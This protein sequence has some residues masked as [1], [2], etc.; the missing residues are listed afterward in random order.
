MA[1]AR[2]ANENGKALLPNGGSVSRGAP[3][4]QFTKRPARKSFRCIYARREASGY[5]TRRD[6]NEGI[7]PRWA[8]HT[9]TSH[10]STPSALTSRL[11]VLV[12]E[13]RSPSS[14]HLRLHLADSLAVVVE[15]D[16]GVVGQQGH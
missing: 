7:P 4:R 15:V 10:S 11:G 16:V 13:L 2:R 9:D 6:S 14:M 1:A 5:M 12:P 3:A 8:E